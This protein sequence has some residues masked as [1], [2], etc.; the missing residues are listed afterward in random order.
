VPV[1]EL[2]FGFV[3]VV[4]VRAFDEDIEF[5]DDEEDEEEEVTC[6]PPACVREDDGPGDGGPAVE[7]L[8]VDCA[9]KAAKRFARKGRFVDIAAASSEIGCMLASE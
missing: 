1:D 9:R 6:E 3:V 4:I 5:A 7:A 2:V 8:Y